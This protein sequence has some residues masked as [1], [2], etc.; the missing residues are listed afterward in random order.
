MHFHPRNARRRPTIQWLTTLLAMVNSA[1][2]ADEPYGT[3]LTA[4][5]DSRLK[6]TRC[7]P[8]LCGHLI[9][10]REPNNDDGSPKRDIYNPDSAQRGRVV[11]GIPILLGLAPTGDHWAGK[12]YNPEDGRTYQATFRLIDAQRAE[13]EGCAAIIFCQTQT[14]TRE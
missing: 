1:A 2:I 10:L 6:L 13:L 7:G 4:D 8:N 9:W 5:R 14:W 11:L 12:I 3:W